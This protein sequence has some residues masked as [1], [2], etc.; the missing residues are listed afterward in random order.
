[1][2]PTALTRTTHHHPIAYYYDDATRRI[3]DE[4][5]A[6][7]LQ[8]FGYAFETDRPLVITDVGTLDI[9]MDGLAQGATVALWEE[10]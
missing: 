2:A 3:V 4:Y 7:D 6:V 10:T 5:M 9:G 8:R 1:M